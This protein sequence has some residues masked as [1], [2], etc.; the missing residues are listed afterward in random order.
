MRI[1][2]LAALACLAVACAAPEPSLPASVDRSIDL[3]PLHDQN[4]D[5]DIVEVTLVASPARVE[6]LTGHPAD[7]WA[8]R[9]GS[10]PDAA[11]RIPGP[12]IEAKRGDTVIVH[13][14]NELEEG[15]TAHFHGVRLPE[16]MDG[17]HEI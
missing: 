9:D 15:T 1:S 5:P 12:L 14:R 17:A 13:L 4:P 2:T 11:P 6:I 3:S 10:I 8:Y 16:S 7:V